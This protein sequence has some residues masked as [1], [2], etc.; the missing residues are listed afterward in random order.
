MT[1]RQAA[2]ASNLGSERH[3]ATVVGLL[4]AQNATIAVAESLTGGLLGAALTDVPGA[5]AVFRGGVTAYAT[6][7]KAS[8]LG[9]DAALLEELGPVHPDIA[10]AMARGVRRLLHVTYGV[11]TTGV[12]GPEPQMGRPPGTVHLSCVGPRGERVRTHSFRG[13]R[14]QIRRE[15]VLAALVLVTEELDL[16][17]AEDGLPAD[18]TA[19][20]A[21]AEDRA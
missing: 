3:A 5:S 10:L 21:T 8:L 14:T 2:S 16:A 12:A 7:L 1:E 6:H 15:S 18:T 4:R 20:D 17:A 13:D 19:E 11:A 9:I